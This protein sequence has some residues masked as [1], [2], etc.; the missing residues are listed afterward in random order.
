MEGFIT[1]WR[2]L[3][4]NIAERSISQRHFKVNSELG[5][6]SCLAS[7]NNPSSLMLF[8]DMHIYELAF[9]GCT[10]AVKYRIYKQTERLRTQPEMNNEVCY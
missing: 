8:I 3:L 1:T 6:F 9:V 5:A 7:I 4:F 2:C 10:C